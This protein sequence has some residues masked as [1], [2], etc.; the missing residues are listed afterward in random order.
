ML[1]ILLLI[2][3]G[4]TGYYIVTFA[5]ATSQVWFTAL[6]ELS[7]LPIFL[8]CLAGVYGLIAGKHRATSFGAMLYI[9]GAVAAVCAVLVARSVW[10][11]TVA[12]AHCQGFF[13]VT[14]S[15]VSDMLLSIQIAPY[16]L[17]LPIFVLGAVCFAVL[18]RQLYLWVQTRPKRARH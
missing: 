18:Y 14:T 3:L 15:C 8:T 11:D 1:L 10:Q 5:I 13:G 2:C 7:L 4:L 17:Q 16:I 9:L 12:R 6:I